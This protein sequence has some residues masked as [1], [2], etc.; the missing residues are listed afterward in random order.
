MNNGNQAPSQLIEPDFSCWRAVRRAA[1]TLSLTRADCSSAAC[2]TMLLLLLLPRPSRLPTPNPILTF[3]R[4]VCLCLCLCLC[5]CVCVRACVRFLLNT[6]HLRDLLHLHPTI[7]FVIE[8]LLQP[9]TFHLASFI[10]ALL[11]I[12]LL[13][14]FPLVVAPPSPTS[15]QHLP[16]SFLALVLAASRQPPRFVFLKRSLWSIAKL[17]TH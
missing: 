13:C 15:R 14:T 9:P 8:L 5:V 3:S 11:S 4:C 7:S 1:G 17:Q 2:V 12:S 16:A 10:S 6:N